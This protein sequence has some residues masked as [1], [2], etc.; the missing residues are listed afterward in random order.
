MVKTKKE[1]Q[2]ANIRNEQG[3]RATDATASKITRECNEQL[4]TSK[5]NNLNILLII[6]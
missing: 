3:N 2:I 5:F 4:Y 1:T 6:L